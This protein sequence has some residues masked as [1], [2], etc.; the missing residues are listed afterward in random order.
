MGEP[1]VPPIYK[2]YRGGCTPSSSPAGGYWG[3]V[4]G[5]KAPLN[6]YT[7]LFQKKSIQKKRG[8]L[9]GG[10]AP[11]RQINKKGVSD[12]RHPPRMQVTLDYG[13]GRLPK[14]YFHIEGLTALYIT[15]LRGLAP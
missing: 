2:I 14:P 4:K 11:S 3:V 5:G 9:E 10:G 1:K 15:G 13:F 7:F 6:I 12:D 8:E